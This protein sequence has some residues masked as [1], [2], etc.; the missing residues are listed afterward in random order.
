MKIK[1]YEKEKGCETVDDIEDGRGHLDVSLLLILLLLLLLSSEGSRNFFRVE[2]AR[3]TILSAGAFSLS[4]SP[5]LS[6]VQFKTHPPLY[7]PIW[8]QSPSGN[9][10]TAIQSRIRFESSSVIII[11][12]HHHGH[13]H[14]PL[15]ILSSGHNTHSNSIRTTCRNPQHRCCRFCCCCCCSDMIISLIFID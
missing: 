9:R 10:S 1:K 4:L 5:S 13:H 6:L 2:I 11:D 15:I 8:K 12:H 14:H 3:E 7:P